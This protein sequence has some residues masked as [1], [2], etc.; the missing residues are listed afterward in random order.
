MDVKTLF[1]LYFAMQAARRVDQVEQ[2]M[3]RRGE[4]FFH[5]SGA[6][7]EGLAALAPHLIPE[8]WLH[9]HYRD[10]ALLIARGLPLRSFFDAVLCTGDASS[11]GRQ[12]S[13]HLCEQ[14]LNIVSMPT[15]VANNALHAVGV[16]A[17]LLHAPGNPLAFCSLG[18]GSTQ[19]GEFYEAV[20]EASREQLPVLFLIEDNRLAISTNTEG[21]TFYCHP[22]GASTELHGVPISHCDGRR[23]EEVYE[24]LGEIVRAIRQDRRPRIVV[25]DVERL[26][27]HTN[28][29]DQRIYRDEAEIQ[30]V[31]EQGDPLRCFEQYLLANNITEEQL[32]A[33]RAEV[34]ERVAEA[35][36][37]AI[38]APEPATT[39]TAKMPIHVEL[40]HPSRERRSDVVPDGLTMKDAI[41]EVLRHHLT[42]DPRV[43]LWGQDIED[44]KGDVFGVTRGLSTAFPGRV[45]NAPLA[46]STIV[47]A[48]IGRAMAGERPIAFIQFADFLPVALNQIIC[49]M[50]T[51]YWRSNGQYRLPLVVMAPCG[52][53]RP[54]L[55]P[56]HSHSME[57]LVA[58][59][60]GLDVFL[61]CTATDAAGMLNAA[62]ASQRPSLF[63][64]PKSLLNDPSQA[65]APEVASQF[66]PIGVA[67]K[68]RSGR[69][70]TFVA[71]G[72]TVRLCARAAEALDRVGVESEIIDL[73]S[74]SPWDQ[75]L[76]LSSAERTARLLVVHED[77]HT[78][79]FGAEVLATVAEKARMPVAMRRVTRPDTIL[80][81]NFANQ[82]E[83]L[84][85]FQRV[86]GAAAELLNLDLEWV[87]ETV[88]E[89]SRYCTVE[90][91]GSGPSDETV[92]I[93][94]LYVAPEQ[95][96]ERGAPLAALEATKS[97]FD[98][99]SPA[100]GCVEEILVEPGETVPVGSPMMRIRVEDSV[101][102]RK[103]VVQE[104]PRK[105]ILTRRASTATIHLPR[106]ETTRRAFDVGMSRVATATGSRVV[107]NRELLA[108][109]SSMT[110][111]DIVRLTGIAERRWATD[112][113]TAISLA[114]KACWQA[115]DQEHLLVDDLD[116]VIC[117]T[118]SP[119]SVTPSMA[120]Q[121][122]NGLSD[123]KTGA[124]L[125]AYDINAAC[126]GYL[127]ALQAG[128]DYLQ[129]MPDGRVLIVTA[130]VLSPLLNP[131]DFDTSILFGDASSATI[132]YGE[133]HFD[134][135][136]TRLYRPELSA[137]GEDGSTLSVPL[138]HEGFIQMKGRRVF[139]E[140]VRTMVASLNR[141]CDRLGISVNDLE[142]VVPHQA[143]QRILDAIQQRIGVPVYSNIRDFGNTSSTSIPLCLSDVMPTGKSGQRYGLCAFGGGFTFGAGVLEKVTD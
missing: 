48:S 103:P 128:Y 127:Y 31:A 123:G 20:A 40:T 54:G 44:P 18:D 57:S 68:V 22:Q 112:Q 96:V 46:E 122:L 135:S 59:V 131:E 89:D 141:V 109:G 8:D 38:Q 108:G 17:T 101:A 21:K 19:E 9:C 97:V 64:Y 11:Q 120:C 60:P 45:R 134:R 6:G 102:R 28:A 12:M 55:G 98:L 118:T 133:G 107:T 126:S 82:L 1:D 140:A 34:T 14:R 77:N 143:N 76:V 111:E 3:V 100:A 4:A 73:R 16:A 129:S 119:T 104:P 37:E 50:G 15:P 125:Q 114:T 26:T 116:L 105:P 124:M 78:C 5:V 115:L 72:N 110:A 42:H 56:F 139:T 130:E 41:R 13:A 7:H 24:H 137:K 86:L 62:L 51:M 93:S 99:S 79:G 113:E 80:P 69:D 53:Y 142:M 52:A 35:E 106:R 90:A 94:E 58:H 29:D 75:Q 95:V 67:R 136:T 2:E 49:E 85:S 74:I 47:G 84:P 71:W 27:S 88:T 87:D 61:P 25:L 121:I 138:P 36:G 63:F 117:S 39:P 66:V 81:C 30:R 132:L 33:V 43:S 65:T 92:T 91:V 83:L 70:I 10:R 32:A 23:P